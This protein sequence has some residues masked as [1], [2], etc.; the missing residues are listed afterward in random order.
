MAK[1]LVNDTIV[2]EDIVWIKTKGWKGILETGKTPIYVSDA[3]IRLGDKMGFTPELLREKWESPVF[4]AKEASLENVR[5]FDVNVNAFEFETLLRNTST[6]EE[7]VCRRVVITLLTSEM[8]IIVPLSTKGCSSELG[9]LTPNG[10]K[11]GKDN[12]LSVLGCEFKNME[13]LNIGIKDSVFHISIN[14]KTV[15]TEK[16]MRP[17]GKIVGV[18]VG[19]EGAGEMQYA[20]LNDEV[21]Q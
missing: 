9:I 17:N 1:L 5:A 14:D 7:C 3:D 2:K 20:K 15:Y 18:R 19:F 12:D 4:T 13:K 6:P 16:Q 11:S 8:A 21:I 10:W